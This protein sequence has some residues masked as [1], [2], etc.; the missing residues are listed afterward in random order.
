[1]KENQLPSWY[2]Q[3]EYSPP[4]YWQVLA[5]GVQWMTSSCQVLAN[6]KSSAWDHIYLCLAHSLH[7]FCSLRPSIDAMSPTHQPGHT[8]FPACPTV[9]P[10]YPTTHPLILSACPTVAVAVAVTVTVAD[11]FTLECILACVKEMRVNGMFPDVRS[12]DNSY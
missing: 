8:T 11:L 9:T 3:L 2:W 7:S 1:M 4:W 10:P 12:E 6:C 5:G